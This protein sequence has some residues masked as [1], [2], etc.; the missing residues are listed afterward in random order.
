MVHCRPALATPPKATELPFDT[1]HL[2]RA[3]S[4]SK[5]RRHPVAKVK[6]NWNNEEDN[7]LIR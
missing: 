5:R 7:R 6:G 2:K 4:N 1:D 3:P